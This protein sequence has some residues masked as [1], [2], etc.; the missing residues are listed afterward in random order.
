MANLSRE[1]DQIES[2]VELSRLEHSITGSQ[3]GGLVWLVYCITPLE[4]MNEAILSRSFSLPSE[5]VSKE[6]ER[7]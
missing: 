3:F 6:R 5:R 1:R 4:L 2:L 7:E